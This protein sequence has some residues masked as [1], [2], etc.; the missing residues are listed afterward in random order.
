MAVANEAISSEGEF[1]WG[2]AA[3]TGF[4]VDP[5]EDLAVVFM[6]QQMPSS[7]YPLRREL[8]NVVYQALT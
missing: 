6:T 1:S 7:R 8:R 2:G 5:A 3:S 4:W